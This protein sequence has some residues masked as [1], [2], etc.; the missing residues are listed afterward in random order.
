MPVSSASKNPACE[1]ALSTLLELGELDILHADQLL[2]PRARTM[3]LTQVRNTKARSRRRAVLL[4]D[5]VVDGEASQRSA[6]AIVPAR[7]SARRRLGL[8]RHDVVARAVEDRRD[9]AASRPAADEETPASI[10]MSASGP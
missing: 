9:L 5:R 2:L 1:I 4:G 3:R 10:H 7:S 8:Q 6:Q